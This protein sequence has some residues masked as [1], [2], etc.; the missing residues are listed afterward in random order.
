M[1]TEEEYRLER[2]GLAKKLKKLQADDLFK[3]V[4]LDAYMRDMELL[5]RYD[6]STETKERLIGISNLHRWMEDTISEAE[7]IV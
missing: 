7:K 4:I 1:M 3:E 6:G 5:L 2:T